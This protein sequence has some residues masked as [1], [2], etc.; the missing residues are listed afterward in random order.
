MMPPT[1]GL[2]VG[3]VLKM[4]PRLSETF[5]LNEILELERQGVGLSIFS[6]RAPTDGRFHGALAGL[7]AAVDYAAAERSESMWRALR[8]VPGEPRFSGWDRAAAFTRRHALAKDLELLLKAALVAARVRQHGLD[9]LHAHFATSAA[10][11]AALAHLMTG[12]PYSFTAHAKDIFRDDVDRNLFAE[13]ASLASFVVTVS[14]YNREFILERMPGVPADRLVRLYN[15]IDLSS[16]RMRGSEP[17]GTP[18]IVSIGRLVPKKGFADL[19]QALALC[20]DRDLEF[21]AT[22]AGEGPEEQALRTLSSRLGLDGHVH[23]AGALT[24]SEVRELIGRATVSALACVEDVDGNRDAL[25]TVLLESLAAGVPVVS[26]RL[27][28]IPEIVGDEG[29]ELVSPGDT[30][31]LAA[32]LTRAC[33]RRIPPGPLRARCERLFDLRRNVDELRTRFAAS[34][35]RPLPT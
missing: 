30:A 10:Q 2:K 34:V 6:L 7:Q 1:A 29:G 13:L 32:A 28:G 15:G 5:V 19:L 12:V 18:H 24:H 8:R 31:G 20:R 25:P 27:A 16:F 3:Y 33:E 9:H 23:F 17:T 21:R 11:V 35:P 26:T 4:F 14:D 22:I